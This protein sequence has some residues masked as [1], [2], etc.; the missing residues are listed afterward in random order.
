MQKIAAELRHRELT[1]EIYNI[2]DEVA[3]YIEHLTESVRDWD[4]ELVEECLAE[5]A[6]ILSDARRD[7]RTLVGELLGLRQ[8]LT[9]GV[10]AGILSAS[11]SADSRLPEPATL[12]A[13]SLEADHPIDGPTVVVSELSE[14]LD[15]RTSSTVEWLDEVMEWVITQTDLVAR[16]LDAVSLPHFYS[17]VGEGVNN[18]VSGWL[19][20]VAQAHP[21]Y[22]RTMRG[23]NPP[24]FLAERA[25]V[26]GIV[27]RVA[28]K[29]A[30]QGRVDAS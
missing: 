10:R 23:D 22:A 26:D 18:A 7:S 25:R 6:E 27:A 15:A 9:S 24:A 5:F 17:R 4:A 29:R 2:G 19:T 8:A 11:A 21:A 30:S 3:D 28:A 20:S 16:N 1:Q 12:N 13:D 14:A